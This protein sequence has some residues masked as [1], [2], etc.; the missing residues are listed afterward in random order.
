MKSKCEG[1][2]YNTQTYGNEEWECKNL[3]PCKQDEPR[4]EID[5]NNCIHLNLTEQKQR[6]LK[7]KERWHR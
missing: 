5:C 7:D 4:E 3:M 6:E 1:C 2:K